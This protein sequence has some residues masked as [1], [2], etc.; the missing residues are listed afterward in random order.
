MCYMGMGRER[1]EKKVQTF[2]SNQPS[3]RLASSHS[4]PSSHDILLMP[5]AH[6]AY[7]IEVKNV[8]LDYT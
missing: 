6:V 7:K 3:F 1:E 8:H 4:S 5:F 2:P